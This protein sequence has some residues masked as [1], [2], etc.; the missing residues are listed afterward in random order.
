MKAVL[1]TCL[2]L[3]KNPLFVLGNMGELGENEKLYHKQIGDFLKKYSDYNLITVGNL[4][5]EINPDGINFETNETCA[6]Y[7]VE[8]IKVGTTIIFKASRAM[9]FEDIIERIKNT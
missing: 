8:N 7:I 6:K 3:Y 5:K 4:A 1:K 2:N 9:K